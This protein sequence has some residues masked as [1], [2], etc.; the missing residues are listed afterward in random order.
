[1]EDVI[2]KMTKKVSLHEGQ[3]SN[4][5]ESKRRAS[6][7]HVSD[8]ANIRIDDSQLE[9]NLAIILDR[10]SAVE[11]R[12]LLCALEKHSRGF[13]R[14]VVEGAWGD[15]RGV[16]EKGGVGMKH[17]PRRPTPRRM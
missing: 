9:K 8:L 11:V 2:T 17:R 15:S 1:M 7:L 12:S 10:L 13:G 14:P 6:D 3:G 4:P 5:F 16:G